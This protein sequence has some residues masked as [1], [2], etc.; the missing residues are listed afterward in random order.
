[1]PWN[2]ADAA[3]RIDS[4]I[5]QHTRL[6][7]SD[8][9]REIDFREP[10]LSLEQA[11]RVDGVHAYVELLEVGALLGTGSA[12][13]HKRFVRLLHLLNRVVSRDV[14]GESGAVL[15]DQQNHRLHLLHHK[16][17]PRAADSPSEARARARERVG[18]ML[19][20]VDAI[21]RLL[22][23]APEFANGAPTPELCV[24][25][26][27][28]VTLVVKNGTRGEREA[29]FIGP[30]ANV[31]AKQ[32]TP[33]RRGVHLGPA[34]REIFSE[35]ALREGEPL[36]L[37][38][39]ESILH[40]ASVTIDHE[41][42]LR[43]WNEDRK[44]FAV[45][46]V[47]FSTPRGSL[48]DVEIDELTPA[49]ARRFDGVAIMADIDGYS[50]YVAQAIRSRSGQEAA[51]RALHVL[52]KVLRDVLESHGGKKVRYIGDCLQG[53]LYFGSDEAA[54]FETVERAI[55]AAAAMRS[56]FDLALSKLSDRPKLG[57]AIGMDFGTLALTR[58]GIKA[59]RDRC[60]VGEALIS[61]EKCQR[62]CTGTQTKVGADLL[63]VAPSWVKFVFERSHTYD[64]LT[65]PVLDAL[66][67]E[68]ERKRRP[69]AATP[70]T[71]PWSR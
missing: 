64:G 35:L 47:E 30:A 60:F 13:N 61:A 24:G 20:T 52:R 34:A 57:L 26:E 29:L 16:P 69:T 37:V 19:A 71:K 44:A 25:V 2:Q 63:R 9:V 17:Y 11:F 12:T 23:S 41:R 56:T 42:V 51:A 8:L 40:H 33:G 59:D 70:A 67:T 49:N 66:R 10:N 21:E 39:R 58:I 1:M 43:A 18:G 50:A 68:F 48:A 62:D 5:E 36:G 45:R 31:A 27:S 65:W 28:G 22:K 46:D 6:E 15:I 38:Q 14:L 3:A 32:I 55:E 54:Q 53:A 4:A 7:V